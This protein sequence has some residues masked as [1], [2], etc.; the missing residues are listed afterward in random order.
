LSFPFI[1]T[2]NVLGAN[3]R[4]NIAAIGAGGKGEV[5]VNGCSS[6]NIFALCDVDEN[7]AAKTFKKFPNAKRYKDFR[8]MLEKEKSIDAVT[9]STPDHMH[10][11][12]ALMAMKM[13]KHVY[14]QKPLTHTVEEARILTEAARKYKV[15][16]QM[17]N[18]GHSDKYL[19]RNVELVQAGVLGKVREAHCWTDRPIWPQGVNRPAEQPPVPSTLDWQLWLGVAPERP[20]SP[21]YVPF[22]WRGYWDF[23]TGALGDMGCHVY[24]MPYWALKLGA[25]TS[26]SAEQEGMTK[27]SPPKWSIVTYEF[28]ER[29]SHPATK[30]I[31]YD[32]GKKPNQ[33]LAKGKKLD[34]N[35][36]ILVG[37]KDTLF[38]P[39]YWGK[40][41]FLSGATY[42]DFKS[43]AET[44]PKPSKF[45]QGHYDEWI[46]ACKGGPAA[47]SNFDYAGPMTEMILLGN[48]AIRAG[49]K[50]E[51]NAKKLK[52]TNDKEAN[53]L[54][55]KKYRRGWKV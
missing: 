31:W 8:V 42:D 12:A 46:A 47:Y 14:C 23:G 2:R 5:D 15:A 18:Q 6:E 49:K 43:V 26:I 9:V 10:F 27:E 44:L 52:V 19:R 55:R 1:S 34:T 39:S 4:L 16:T 13:R 3:S 51:W 11:P 29:Q 45:D 41:E 17:G 30:F 38:V 32:G 36:V 33:D 50:I 20:Y 22:K 7:N 24:D 25:P 35:G 54:I 21:A 37:E 28:A 53:Q 40:A 48:V